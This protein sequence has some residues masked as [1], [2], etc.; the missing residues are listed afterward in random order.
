MYLC[1]L[2][3]MQN[4]IYVCLYTC[5]CVYICMNMYVDKS[6]YALCIYPHT[7]IAWIH[8]CICEYKCAY[9]VSM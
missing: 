1:M 3:D 2:P 7:Y 8:T 4:D 6:M 9:V 5:I